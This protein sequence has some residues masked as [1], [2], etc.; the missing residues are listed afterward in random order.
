[1]AGAEF[2]KTHLTKIKESARFLSA[3]LS[4][5]FYVERKVPMNSF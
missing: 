5:A 3:L 1:M 4:K 2:L